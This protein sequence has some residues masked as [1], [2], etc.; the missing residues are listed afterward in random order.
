VN[1]YFLRINFSKP[2]LED[3]ESSASYD[4]SSGNLTVTLTKENKGQVFGD[5]DL[6]AKLLAPRR[7]TQDSYPSIEV[8]SV[9]NRPEDDLVSKTE[10]LSLERNE[11]AEGRS[12][13]KL[14]YIFLPTFHFSLAQLR[15]TTGNYLKRS[16]ASFH[17]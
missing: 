13:K 6:L 8:L 9:E 1:P 14:A 4:P 17:L 3:E 10:A 12:L 2:V 5:L 11:I 15:R 7:S 16:Q